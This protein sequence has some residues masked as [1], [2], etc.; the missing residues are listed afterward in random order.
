MNFSKA[1]SVATFTAEPAYRVARHWDAT[2]QDWRTR[3]V[4]N[5]PHPEVPHFAPASETRP[6][7]SARERATW[8]AELS[9]L[10]EAP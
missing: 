10:A 3:L 7:P 9:E 1:T 2:R 6:A 4:P 5:E 8:L